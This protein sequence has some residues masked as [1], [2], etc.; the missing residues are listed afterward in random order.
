MSDPLQLDRTDEV[1]VV[2]AKAAIAGR[3]M[4]RLGETIGDDRAAELYAG[5]MADIAEL[6]ADVA[7][8]AE[9]AAVVAHA[10]RGEHESFAPFRRRD[11]DFVDQGGGD[12]GARLDRIV[13]RCFEAGAE[14]VAVVGSD[15]PTLRRRHFRQM[16]E[17]LESA[18]VAFGPSFDG[19]YYLVGLERPLPELFD[20]I[21]WSTP[22]V[23]HQSLERARGA[24]VLCELLEFWYDIDTFDDLRRLR[25]HVLEY[26]AER[27]GEAPPETATLL[28]QMDREGIFAESS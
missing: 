4:T 3:S 20:R 28:R 22:R 24:E 23:L 17:A 6:V 12:L 26:L 19:G 2:F 5:F 1:L 9:G 27:D 8:R 11:F 14:R 7:D 25:T 18:D 16:R 10:G 21:D 13:G 15:S